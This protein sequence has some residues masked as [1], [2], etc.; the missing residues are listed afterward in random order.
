LPLIHAFQ[1][2]KAKDVKS[3]K[4]KIKKGVKSKDIKE[5]IQFAE[6]N[7]G[8]EYA[9][10]KQDEYAMKAKDALKSYPDSEVKT[11]LYQFVDYVIKRSM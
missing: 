9:K 10:Q 7:N 2:A 8:I 3:I 5:I 11:A 6:A 1:V 4:S